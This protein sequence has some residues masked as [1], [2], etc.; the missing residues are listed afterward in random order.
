MSATSDPSRRDFLKATAVLGGTFVATDAGAEEASPESSP[1]VPLDPARLA[2]AAGD[3]A[4][5]RA[6]SLP[7]ARWIWFPSSRTLANTMILFRRAFDLPSAPRRATGWILG[8]SRYLLFANGRR[9]QFGPAPCDP[10]FEELDPMD[11]TEVLKAGR[12]AIGVQVLYY[13]HGD[14]TWP[15][16]KPGLLG[17]LEIELADGTK[18]TIA[19]DDAWQAHY[20]RAWRPGQFKRWYLRAFQEDFDA[21]RFPHGWHE[22]GFAPDRDWV[23]AMV[24]QGAAD[25]PSLA[26]GYGD[27]ALDVGA[28]RSGTEL[29]R[30]S[31]PMM[32]EDWRPAKRLAESFHLEW[33]RSPEAYF[34]LGAPDSYEVERVPVAGETESGPWE[35]EVREGRAMA[36][37]FEFAEQIVGW[38]AFTIEAPEGTVVELMTQE[39]HAVGGP[40]LLDTHFHAWSR[41][42]CRAGSNRFEA[43]DFESLRWLQLHVRNATGRVRIREV[44]V[45]RRQFPWPREPRV[46][47]SD[48]ALQRLVDASINTLHNSAQETVVDGMGRERQQYSGDGG[49]QMHA[50]YYAFGETRL[51]AR[52]VRTF[53]QGM[54]LDG[55]FLDCWP[56][57]DRLARLMERQL[58]LTDWGPLLDH[59]VGFNFDNFY[60]LQHTGDLKPLGEVYPRLLRFAAY[61]RGIRGKD[62]L[63]PVEG[64]GVP[65]VWLDHQAYRRPRHKQCAF[66]L[67]AAAML[68]NALPA[69]ARAFGDEANAVAAERFGAALRQATVAKYWSP[70]RGLFVNNLPWLD[71]EKEIRTCDRSLATAILFDQCPAGRIA[72]VVSVLADAPSSL[73]ESYPCNAGWRYWALAKAGRVDVVLRALRERWATMPSVL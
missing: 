52:F 40:P 26:T 73:G 9:I 66:N 54:T 13:G 17:W 28:P 21:R 5:T 43:F 33:R 44:G 18:R 45:R 48:P 8:S 10:R 24:L 67:Y 31:I 53:S 61:L 2:A 34:E 59:G 1:F 19:T 14:G 7:G 41:F 36:L 12:N 64:L 16:G 55:Y 65:A 62:G 49:H 3:G 58:G 71:E 37:T 70:A 27:Y 57:Y 15:A 23:N 4:E 42:T 50:I 25:K 68:E 20:A 56:A 46:R 60:Y 32:R 35:V 51:P 69:I 72:E 22:P 11:L 38:P 6:P 30:R 47:V 63:L 29:R 39:G